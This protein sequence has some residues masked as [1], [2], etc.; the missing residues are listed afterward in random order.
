MEK[1]RRPNSSGK[2]R[3]QKLICN[4]IRPATYEQ[5]FPPKLVVTP[6]RSFIPPNFFFPQASTKKEPEY[7]VIFNVAGDPKDLFPV[8]IYLSS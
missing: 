3:N 1:H 2:T 5:F 4:D 7:N 6:T 8:F